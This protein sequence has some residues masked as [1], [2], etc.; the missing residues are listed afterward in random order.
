M[1]PYLFAPIAIAGLVVTAGTTS[2]IKAEFGIVR[3]GQQVAAMFT[4]RTIMLSS[5]SPDSNPFGSDTAARLRSDFDPTHNMRGVSTP[6]PDTSV[7]VI[8]VSETWDKIQAPAAS[9]TP[10]AKHE[11]TLHLSRNSKLDRAFDTEYTWKIPDKGKAPKDPNNFE[12]RSSLQEPLVALSG[13]RS[14][15]P[16]VKFAFDSKTFAEE[17]EQIAKQFQ[18]MKLEKWNERQDEQFKKLQA[19][20][21]HYNDLSN[22][23]TVIRVDPIQFVSDAENA[24]I[25]SATQAKS[26]T[27]TDFSTNPNN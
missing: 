24:A 21:V 16:D 5:E 9:R 10:R 19:Y 6:V 14:K 11:A 26:Q 22:G 18:T 15:C 23:T 13:S 7:E 12:L 1:K 25:D 8:P 2:I 27:D 20:T 4:P 3:T 17:Q